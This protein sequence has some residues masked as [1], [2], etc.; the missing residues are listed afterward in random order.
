MKRTIAFLSLVLVFSAMAFSQTN[1]VKTGQ[2]KAACC[3]AC[4]GDKCGKTCC[5]SGCTDACC[6]GK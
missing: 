2:L 3:G 5:Q 1:L 6:K 4:C